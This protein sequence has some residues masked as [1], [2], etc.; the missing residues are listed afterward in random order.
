[1]GLTFFSESWCPLLLADKEQESGGDIVISLFFKIYFYLLLMQ[2]HMCA[3]LLCLYPYVCKCPQKPEDDVRCPGTEVTCSG[4]SP[5]VG[6]GN[7]TL[8]LYKTRMFS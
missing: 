5:Y 8:V 6:A 4:E 2:R 7:P 3:R 1:M